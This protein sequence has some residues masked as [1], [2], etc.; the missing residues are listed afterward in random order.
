[1]GAIRYHF[2]NIIKFRVLFLMMLP[3]LAIVIFN[4]YVPMFGVVLAF[5]NYTFSDGI[6]G[7]A[8]AGWTNFKYLFQTDIAWLATRNTIMYNAIF[9]ALNTVCAIGLAILLNEIR[10][11][12]WKTIFQ[13][14]MLFPYFLSYVAVSYV[15]YAFLGESGFM[16]T[17]MLKWLGQDAVSWY[18][19]PDKWHFILPLVNT[20]KHVGYFAIVYLA[21]IVSIDT[22]YYEAAVI[23]GASKWRQIRYIT[24]PM[25]LPVIVIMTLLQ[26]SRIFNADFG[27]FY[28]ATL[29]S[30]ALQNATEVM[31]TFVYRN[32]LLNG[33]V[34]M[35]S[36][37]GLYQSFVGFVLVLASNAIV[38]RINKEN[39]LF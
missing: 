17:S 3:T 12:R 31:D 32:F 22:E 1:M 13:S 19:S 25:M 14:T 10:S 16:N 27:L 20:W 8:W 15:L 33:D 30:G 38:R 23:D 37:A 34:G 36:A 18:S 39:A 21:A 26:V 11:K 28:Q 7:S 29:N 35:S 4:N 5:K 9:I 24:I 6:W 2:R